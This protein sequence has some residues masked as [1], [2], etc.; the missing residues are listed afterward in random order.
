MNKKIL[1]VILFIAF[2]LRFYKLSNIPAGFFFDEATVGVNSY[3]LSQNL[4][5]EF[6]NFLPD[7]IKI[8]D[9][10]RHVAIFYITTPFI[11]ILGLSEFAVRSATAIFGVGIVVATFLITNIIT[12]SKQVSLLAAFLVSVSPW[13]VNLSRSSNEVIVALFFLLVA[14]IF[15]LLAFKKETKMLFLPAYIFYLFSWFSYSAAILLNFLHLSFIVLIF[16]FFFKKS[17]SIK[18]AGLICLISFVIFP[19]LFYWLTSPQKIQG[20]FNQVSVFAEKGTQLL[21]EEAIREDGTRDSSRVL[22][23]RFFHNKPNSYF[24]A[25]TRSYSQYFSGQFLLGKEQLPV[26][27]RIPNTTLI[28]PVE[29]LLLIFGLFIVVRKISWGGAFMVFWLLIGPVPAALTT[30]DTPNMQRAIFMLPSLQIIIALGING[31]IGYKGQIYGFLKKTRSK[32]ILIGFIAVI[33]FY[34]FASFMHQLLIHQ[35][36]NKIWY[37]NSEWKDGSLMIE[38]FSKDYQDVVMTKGKT[39]PHYYLMFFSDDYRGQYEDGK[40]YLSNRNLSQTWDLGKYSF[41]HQDCILPPVEKVKLGT[42]YINGQ[43]CKIPNWA[44]ILAEAKT[45][46]GVTMLTFIDIPLS[47]RQLDELIRLEEEKRKQQNLL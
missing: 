23:T 19:N 41:V 1:L 34:Y 38:R 40:E 47:Q 46:D 2:I 12:N 11:K 39:E 37:R 16:L 36:I 9:D 14:D 18:T 24:S 8:G 6:G 44:R 30:E 20:R 3:F 7:F 4:H 26:R 31:L 5:D 42:L 32:N 13:L 21:L 27:Y 10:F 45:P 22:L 33:Y 17:L 35:P 43:N 15:A 29:V 25:I 28:Y